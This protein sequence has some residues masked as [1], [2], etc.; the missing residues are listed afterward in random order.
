MRHG[1]LVVIVLA[2]CNGD[3]PFQ[4][5]FRIT[6]GDT[7]ACFTPG[8]TRATSCSDVTMMCD[9]V[10]RIEIAA[11]SDP[12]APYISTCKPLSGM[13]ACAIAG[14][15][16]PLPAMPIPR[17]RLQVTMAVYPTRWTF[18]GQTLSLPTDPATN[19]PE[20]PP[21]LSLA[22][23]GFPLEH[24]PDCDP[25]VT[26]P[27]DMRFCWPPPAIGGSTYYNPGDAETVVDLGCSD[28]TEL[29]DPVACRGEQKTAVSATVTDF[30]T[31]VS[32]SP[33][34]A[35]RLAVAIG[36]PTATGSGSWMLE[37]GDETPLART[38]VQ[39]IPGWGGDTTQTFSS[40]VCLAVLEDNAQATTAVSCQ[41]VAPNP[42]RIDLTGVRLAKP[43]LD[44]ILAA[45]NKPTFPEQ[46]LVVGIVLDN[47][48]NPLRNMHVTLTPPAG[49]TGPTPSVEYLSSD[50][51][52][53]LNPIVGT[54]TNGIFISEDAPFGTTFTV[55]SGSPVNTIPPRLGGLVE[56]KVTMV[57]L[58][59]THPL[60]S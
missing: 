46:G 18:E 34:T 26:D 40:A 59:F 30:D 2:A 16:L 55:S 47:L 44:Q 37:S 12:S 15:D 60:G 24:E 48:G 27:T 9:A 41:A 14:I 38:V 19:Q 51:T 21:Q 31:D 25:S 36:E 49:A 33:S 53:I 3:P 52:G 32:V 20:C 4:L 13:D 10:A 45:I 17:Q 29:T 58:Q 23:D 7:Q 42:S 35:D 5:R 11:P 54:S 8:G 39:P 6:Q 1:L 43:T 57:V 56:G 28:L 50:R 22:A